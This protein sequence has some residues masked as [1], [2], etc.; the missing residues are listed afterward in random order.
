ML[1]ALSLG[2]RLLRDVFREKC[3]YPIGGWIETFGSPYLTALPVEER[4]PFLAEVTEVLRPR[5]LGDLEAGRS[6]RRRAG[7]IAKHA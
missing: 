7:E 1:E 5:L 2:L 6:R 4:A 3:D